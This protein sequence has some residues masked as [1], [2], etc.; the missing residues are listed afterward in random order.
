MGYMVIIRHRSSK[1]AFGAKNVHNPFFRDTRYDDDPKDD[2]LKPGLQGSGNCRLRTSGTHPGRLPTRCAST[3][4][5]RMMESLF[6]NNTI[7]VITIVIVIV[8]IIAIF[9]IEIL[10]R[11]P[12]RCASTFKRMMMENLFVTITIMILPRRPTRCASTEKRRMAE[13]FSSSVS[14]TLTL[15][16]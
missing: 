9:A 13:T 3:F 6:V 15:N 14:E 5:R 12:T 1:S 11:G 16:T 7:I 10:P 2:G 8:I 4:K